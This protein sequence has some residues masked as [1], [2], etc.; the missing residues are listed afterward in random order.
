[1]LYITFFNISFS[2]TVL[3]KPELLKKIGDL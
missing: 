3:R 1:M 2:A